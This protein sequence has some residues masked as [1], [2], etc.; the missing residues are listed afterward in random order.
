MSRTL[1]RAPCTI[2]P[3]AFLLT[4][5]I[6]Q[7]MDLAIGITPA[8]IGISNSKRRDSWLPRVFSCGSTLLV[9]LLLL[10][11][12]TAVAQVPPTCPADLDTANIIEHDFTVS[13]CELCDTGTVRMIIRNPYEEDDDADFSDIVITENLAA[14]GLTYVANST[15]FTATNLPGPPPLVEPVLGGANN[16]VLTWTLSNLFTMDAPLVGGAGL[17]PTLEVEFNVERFAP[18]GEEG[19]VAANRT[20]GAAVEFTPSCD[21]GYRHTSTTGSGI[22][23][24][25][26]PVPVVIKTGRNV[27]AGQDA[28][29]YSDPV[30][31]HE[32]DDV[33]WR[34]EVQNSGLADLQDLKFT[35]IIDP[36][37]FVID[38]VCANE[39]DADSV[40]SGGAA[41]GCVAYP[42]VT[43][44]PDLAVADLFGGAPPYIAAPAGG[45]GFFFIVG[46]V[47]DSCSNRVNSVSGVEWG[48][49]AQAPPGGIGTTSTGASTQDD[50]LMSTLA[51]ANTL[52]VDVALTGTNTAQPMGGKGTVTITITNNT[53]GTIKGGATGIRIQN[54]LPEDYVIDTTFDPTVAMTPAYGNTYPGMLDTIEW[55]NPQPGTYPLVTNDPLLP[56]LNT[57]LEF[58]VTSSTVHPDFP[59]QF[60]ML[61]HGDVLTITFRTVL[62][63]PQYY[64]KEAYLDVREEQPASDPPDTDPTESFAISNQLDIWFE[65]FCTATEHQLTFNDNDTADP[66]DI[67]LDMIGTELVY[68]LTNTDVLPLTVQLNNNGGH[69]ADDYFAYVTFGEAMEIQ[70]APASCSVTTNPPAMPVWQLPVALPA[71]A[72]VYQCDPGVV[73]AGGT[74]QLDFEVAKNPDV[75]ADDD[76]TFRADVIGEITLSDGTPLWFPTPTARGDGILD[77]ANNYTIDAL[78][79]RVVG[80]NLLKSQQGICT[81]NNPPPGSP[82]SLIQIGEECEFHIESGGWF[83][84]E[85]PG[86]TYIA[87]QDI[88][89]VDNIPDG[90]GYISSTDPFAPGYSTGQVL[91]AT[92]NPPPAPLTE[93]PFDWTHNTVVPAERI[94]ERD[95]WFRVD[96]TTRLLNDP[97][98]TVAPPNQHADLSSNVLTSTFE[99]V[100]FNPLTGLEEVY[101]LSTSTIGYPPEFRRRVDL[102]V[103]EPRLILTKEVCN[104]T[105]YGTGP[106]CTN[107]VTLA[108]DG[109]AFDTYIY[110]INVL[111]EAASGSVTRAP[112]Y[113][114]TVTSVTDPT[115]LIYVD[116]LETD[117]LDN[118]GD[119]AIDEGGGEGQIV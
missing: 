49:E 52:D 67:D 15:T 40:A 4:A 35:D 29:N 114:I 8:M 19:L 86:F 38:Y 24:L 100:F 72:T 87:V 54:L 13:F 34:I 90:Q 57:D 112:A 10:V 102:T 5:A 69:D 109:D 64:D 105:I 9:A 14:S 111:N 101:T 117:G 115:D 59:D 79:A 61:R 48:C 32:N 58:L 104:E 3:R 18:L 12:G 6:E 31:G 46:R 65:E 20:I 94:T 75:N 88:Q 53:G 99:A 110:R 28:A 21:L 98:D 78:R 7:A 118:D 60:N 77:R 41:G 26:E 96:V 83:G 119:T 50:A 91:N 16:E 106:G 17:E 89:V 80:Y 71:S 74:L 23:P 55:T 56:L 33:I 85:T 92:L 97:I 66:E 63:D 103:T 42:A 37:N 108:D 107:F 113:D 27:D 45:S 1:A 44:L 93:N 116:P 43:S 51:V 25:N 76:L 30:Y 47:T 68:I 2:A 62:I 22:L 11:S 36:G 73:P 39:A 70:T 82:D 95:H 84:F 81:E